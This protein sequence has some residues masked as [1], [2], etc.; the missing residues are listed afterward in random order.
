M[1]LGNPEVGPCL[2]LCLVFPPVPAR[3]QEPSL[4][5][6]R[7]GRQESTCGRTPR[8]GANTGVGDLEDLW[9]PARMTSRRQWCFQFPLAW[10][11]T[12][13]CN[14]RRNKRWLQTSA[15]SK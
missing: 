5:E 3:Q 7:C 11:E 12:A 13:P 6:F 14:S 4:I 9:H 2:I 1:H 15:G 10:P 8:N